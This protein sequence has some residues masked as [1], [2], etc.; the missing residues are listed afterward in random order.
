ML[1][2]LVPIVRSYD[3]Y[4]FANDVNGISIDENRECK[5]AFD[6]ITYKASLSNKQN[7]FKEHMDKGQEGSS[8]IADMLSALR[9]TVLQ[10]TSQQFQNNKS[11]NRCNECRMYTLSSS[12]LD[13][14]ISEQHD[15]YFACVATRKQSYRCIVGGR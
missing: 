4:Y 2:R 6:S 8:N 3:E 15:S 7:S 14:H 5:S 12:L 1:L 10:T 11:A 9:T 13:L